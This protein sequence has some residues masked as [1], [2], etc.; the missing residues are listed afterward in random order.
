MEK[1]TYSNFFSGC[2]KKNPNLWATRKC[3]IST[4]LHIS[5]PGIKA[6][7]LNNIHLSDNFLQHV[8]IL[9]IRTMYQS[10]NSCTSQSSFSSPKF[11]PH[12]AISTPNRAN[13]HVNNGPTC[14]NTWGSYCKVTKSYLLMTTPTVFVYTVYEGSHQVEISN[15]QIAKHKW[16]LPSVKYMSYCISGQQLPRRCQWLQKLLIS[17]GHY[18]GDSNGC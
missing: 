12:P 14:T 13:K 18:R 1:F 15:L 11:P 5:M 7:L 9:P 16:S 3:I 17:V 6:W 4:A 2:E 10:T 8:C